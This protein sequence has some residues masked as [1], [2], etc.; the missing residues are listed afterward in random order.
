MFYYKILG[1]FV[2][3]MMNLVRYYFVQQFWMACHIMHENCKEFKI[4]IESQEEE[5]GLDN[6][7]QNKQHHKRIRNMITSVDD[8]FKYLVA[9]FISVSI[10]GTLT[11]ISQIW[12]LYINDELS[13]EHKIVLPVIILASVYVLGFSLYKAVTIPSEF[14]KAIELYILK[15]GYTEDE[16]YEKGFIKK[17]SLYFI[18]TYLYLY[19]SKSRNWKHCFVF[20]TI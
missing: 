13:F 20:K 12:Q 18:Y 5:N 16:N 19:A 7:K 4:L 10:I 2:L 3:F 15:V 1:L 8:R 17:V 14:K 9:F 11:P 6:L